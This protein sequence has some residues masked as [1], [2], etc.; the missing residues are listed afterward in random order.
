[1]F[2]LSRNL[3]LFVTIF[4]FFIFSADTSTAVYKY[5]GKIHPGK[6][7][8][9]EVTEVLGE[10]LEEVIANTFKYKSSTDGIDLF[11]VEYKEQDGGL[12]V[13]KMDV[14]FSKPYKSKALAKS[15]KFPD[16]IS[17]K[18]NSFGKYQEFFGTNYSVIFTHKTKSPKSGVATM[19]IYNKE[20]FDSL[21]IKPD[22]RSVKETEKP[23][24]KDKTKTAKKPPK[25]EVPKLTP[26]AKLHLQQGMTYV[27]IAKANPATAKENYSNALIEFNNAID[28]YPNYAE[29]YS[30]R[31]ALYMQ[32][33]KY[34]KAEK[35]LSKAD[36]LKPKD[37][38]IQYNLAALY[39][40][41]KKND[42]ALEA[43]NKALELG[44][45][46]YDALR[47]RGKGSDPDLRNLRKDPGYKEILEKHKVFILD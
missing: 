43:L 25:K 35:D 40:I 26:E 14:I 20:R 33:K 29:A 11:L 44:F 42:L 31:G 7:T 15:M 30:N 46:N 13:D 23:D 9:A 39:S 45:N 24:K 16:P 10:P 18:V 12:V 36:N 21:G 5:K 41:Q 47:P 6:T 4:F 17:S 34:N 3:I 32:Q 22:V 1:M 37:P 27:T 38:I 28:D 8:K 2:W 19:S